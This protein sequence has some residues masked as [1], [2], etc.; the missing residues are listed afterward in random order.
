M[1]NERIEAEEG[2]IDSRKVKIIMLI[3]IKNLKL[4]LK[5]EIRENF[6]FN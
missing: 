1:C 5:L 2:K 4:R 3:K 6:I